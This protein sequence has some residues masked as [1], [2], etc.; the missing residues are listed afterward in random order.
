MFEVIL[1]SG[2][3]IVSRTKFSNMDDAFYFISQN[4]RKYTCQ[5][6][7]LDYFGRK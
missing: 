5:F 7:D 2:R 4:E 1:K 3:K 6:I